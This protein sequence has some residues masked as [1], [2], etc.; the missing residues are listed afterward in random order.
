MKNIKAIER[1]EFQDFLDIESKK[2]Q[3]CA[4]YFGTSQNLSVT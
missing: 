1:F 2:L 4:L 3:S